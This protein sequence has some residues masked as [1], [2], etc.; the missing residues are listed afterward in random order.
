[1]YGVHRDAMQTSATDLESIIYQT[2]CADL[3][4]NKVVKCAN[5][6]TS[7]ITDLIESVEPSFQADLVLFLKKWLIADFCLQYNF[8]RVLVATTGHG[9]A[10][11]LLSQLSKGRGASI[12]D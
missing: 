10:I 1:M 6:A 2:M 12:A 9:I 7:K 4:I 8:K 3:P 5:G 11:K